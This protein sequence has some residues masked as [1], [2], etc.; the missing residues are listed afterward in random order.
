MSIVGIIAEFNPLHSGHEYLISE[1]KALGQVATVIS[2]NFVQR[3]DT[4]VAPKEIRAKAA[5]SAGADLVAELPVLWSMST[6]QNF[7]IG[8]VSALVNLGCDTLMFGSETGEIELLLKIAEILTGV[9]FRDC[10]EKYC[11]SGMT[12]AAAR[13]KACE[14]LG[15]QK[16]ILD[17]PNNNLGIEYIVAA[18]RLG[19]DLQFKTVK[20]RGAQHDST[21]VREFVSASLLREKLLDGDRE[22]CRRFM[23][24]DVLELFDSGSLSDIKNIEKGIL[25]VLRTKTVGDLKQL[26]DLSEGVENKLYNEIRLANSL[27]ELYNG[28][29]VK[30]YPMARVRRL[31]L[32]AFLGF[33]NEYFMK[34]LPYV[35]VLGFN[36]NGREIIKNAKKISSVPI[37]TRVSEI[38]DE[39]VFKT[40]CRATDLYNLSLRKPEECGK[41]FTVKL[42]KAEGDDE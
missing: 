23:S 6:A 2:G 34:P 40:E 31:V 1:A 5:L 12:F 20:R 30:R 19:A 27:E 15:A 38:K 41:E 32:S 33:D 39:K 11:A 8:G 18:K 28:I 22:F 9:E 16:G 14:E 26:P 4:A 42:I 35:R 29:K 36:K 21:A 25:S 7:A 24:E 13:Q 10:L 17:K 3:G 37:V